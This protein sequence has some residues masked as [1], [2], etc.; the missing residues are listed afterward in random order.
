MGT[1]TVPVFKP[2]ALATL[3]CGECYMPSGIPERVMHDG[4]RAYS[5]QTA[6]IPAMS[7]NIF[8][9]DLRGLQSCLRGT[10]KTCSISFLRLV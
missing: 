8:S 5:S 2:R 10:V 7:C 6:K 3:P 4:L 9:V 1:A